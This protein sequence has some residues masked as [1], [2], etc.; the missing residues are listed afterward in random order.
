M[1]GSLRIQFDDADAFR[2]E[3]HKNIAKGGAFIATARTFELRSIIEVEL[4]LGFCGENLVLEAE[5]V[6]ELPGPHSKGPQSLSI[7]RAAEST[8]RN[9]LSGLPP[10]S[11]TL[12]KNDCAAAI[13]RYNP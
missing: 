1:S 8:C 2:D 9:Y 7:L 12:A 10:Q 13:P 5:V 4:D 11:T 3:F 6:H